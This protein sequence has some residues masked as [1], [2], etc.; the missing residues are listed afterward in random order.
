MYWLRF[1]TGHKQWDQ[2]D[3]QKLL[4]LLLSTERNSH[5]LSAVVDGDKY[6]AY[7]CMY[8]N[9]YLT[10]LFASVVY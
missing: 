1:G 6:S 5:Y 7:Q 3:E 10:C 4:L 8:K 9:N 2:Q